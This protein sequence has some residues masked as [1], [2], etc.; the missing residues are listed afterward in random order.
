M[1][2]DTNNTEECQHAKPMWTEIASRNQRGKT[3]N[4][5]PP[6]SPALSPKTTMTTTDYYSPLAHKPESIEMIKKL[7]LFPPPPNLLARQSRH[8]NIATNP[9][10]SHL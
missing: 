10:T 2:E 6:S 9:A 3:P 8:P 7:R 5:P 1:F 4:P